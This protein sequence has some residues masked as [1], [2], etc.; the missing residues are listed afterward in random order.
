M[1]TPLLHEVA[2]RP[3]PPPHRRAAALGA[4]LLCAV[5]LASLSPGSTP[6]SLGGSASASLAAH[7]NASRRNVSTAASCRNN[8]TMYLYKYTLA[9]SLAE[10]DGKWADEMFGC[11]Y[12]T[13]TDTHGC[14]QLGKTSCFPESLA[15]G[16][17]FV[18][19][20]A[21]EAGPRGVADWDGYQQRLN[22]KSF[23]KGQ[24]N[25]FMHYALVLYTPD[26]TAMASYLVTNGV[27]FLARKGVSPVDGYTWYTL[28]VASP[29]GK[30]FELTSAKLDDGTGLNVSAIAEWHAADE[31]PLCHYSSTYT[32]EELTTWHEVF[33][34]ELTGDTVSD[35]F[36]PI[37]A[38]VAVAS[39]DAVSAWFA[40]AVPAARFEAGTGGGA[41]SSCKTLTTT[42]GAYTERDF[43]M[44][45]RYVENAAA[46]TD[47]GASVA[48][49][50]EYVARVNANYTGVDRGW[51]AWYDRHLGVLFE[52]CA[53]D[54]YMLVFALQNVSFLP[55]GR[56]GRTEDSD[57]SRDHVWTEGVQGYG[58][59]MQGNFSYEF[60]SSYEVFDWC[61]WDTNPRHAHRNASRNATQ[62]S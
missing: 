4:V 54:D 34:V 52:E 2:G 9:S 23:S 55:H 51:S 48:D 37:R 38:S 42:M 50:V 26:L 11:E 45:V 10:R 29:S 25:G 21:T 13:V 7:T 44:E 16:L 12:K 20:E 31:C 57:T 24:F 19:N 1:E 41:N 56:S 58:L 3:A 15:F 35:K 28:V 14:A 30:I 61:S 49:F 17:H 36:L 46:P 18:D 32:A 40:A 47:G 62:Q 59:E 33:S 8:D 53:L 39:V 60:K 43:A 27:D 6:P 22:T 5:G